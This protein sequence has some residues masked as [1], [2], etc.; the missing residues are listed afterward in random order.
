MLISLAGD[1]P[2]DDVTT[3]QL[4]SPSVH[5]S[6]ES[7]ALRL[8]PYSHLVNAGRQQTPCCEP[9]IFYMVLMACWM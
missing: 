9:Q 5:A 3:L 1:S 6:H 7:T 4:V 2:T 8:E